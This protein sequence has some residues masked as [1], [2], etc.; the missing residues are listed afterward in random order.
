MPDL[1]AIRF[2]NWPMFEKLEAGKWPKYPVPRKDTMK[3][4]LAISGSLFGLITVLHVLRVFDEW[5]G[6]KNNPAQLAEMVGLGILA[7]GLCC[8]AVQLLLKP[9]RT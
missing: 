9:A 4:Y 2:A 7:A 8:W 1:G 5:Q 6:M 3:A